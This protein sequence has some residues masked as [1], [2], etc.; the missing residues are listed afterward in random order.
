MSPRT[1]LWKNAWA[2]ARPRSSNRLLGRDLSSRSSTPWKKRTLGT[3]MRAASSFHG[4]IMPFSSD[5]HTCMTAAFPTKRLLST[6]ATTADSLE[7]GEDYCLTRRKGM[8]CVAIVAH[9]DHGKTSLVDC[10][11]RASSSEDD[12]SVA[13]D[14]LMDSG[15]LEKERGITITSKVTR[16]HYTSKNSEGTEPVIVNIADRY[17]CIRETNMLPVFPCDRSGKTAA[18]PQLTH[19]RCFRF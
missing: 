9:V 4:A 16:V 5:L 1:L 12:S 10:L 11:L 17:V 8:R 18:S 19:L 7:L 15:D 3:T 14:R 13:V 6:E 2:R